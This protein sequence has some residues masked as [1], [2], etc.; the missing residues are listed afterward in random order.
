MTALAIHRMRTRYRLPARDAAATR[1]RLDRVRAALLDDWLEATLEQAGVRG[2]EE[3]CIRRVAVAVRLAARHGD[4]ALALAWSE[5]IAAAIRS[6]R[7]AGGA[8]V[9]RY[10]SRMQAWIDCADGVARGDL[11]HAWGWRQLGL[12]RGGDDSGAA[13]ATAELVR[14]L[15]ASPRVVVPVLVALSRTEALARLASRLDAAD[16]SALAAAALDAHG[17]PPALLDAPTA[18]VPR[19]LANAAV[20]EGFAARVLER[21]P[22]AIRSR[23]ATASARAA[24]ILVCLAHDPALSRAGVEPARHAVDAV[25]QAIADH[26]VPASAPPATE[27]AA[28]R[29]DA[30]AARARA[31]GRT[32]WGGLL[33]LLHLLAPAGVLD[34]LAGMDAARTLRWALHQLATALAPVEARDAAALAFA[35]LAPDAAP[36]SEGEPPATAAEQAMIAE[37]GERVTSRL[38]AALDAADEPAT[39]L[40]VRVCRRPAE[41]VADPGWIEVRLPLSQV[42]TALR[43]AG[44]DLHPDWLPWLGAVVRFVYA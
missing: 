43:R 6:Q 29:D 20:A 37:L 23:L 33:F 38:R 42:G 28:A 14:A 19:A 9:I 10:A 40:L 11:A 7:A 39:A 5:A 41:I 31:T 27:T 4:A 21:S 3:V 8:E 15:A 25:A 34:A 36:P 22:L 12:W 30:A 17:A 24:A 16:W 1:A 35:G 18:L 26:I 32:E 44:L 2:E 13:A